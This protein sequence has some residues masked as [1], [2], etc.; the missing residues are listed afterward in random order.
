M[1]TSTLF[2]SEVWDTIKLYLFENSYVN[3]DDYDSLNDND[4]FLH[5]G[6]IKHILQNKSNI[7][8]I[9]IV[10]LNLYITAE[11]YLMVD[12][13]MVESIKND[14]L[15]VNYETN[16]FNKNSEYTYY[17]MNTLSNHKYLAPTVELYIKSFY[18]KNKFIIRRK[19][20][21]DNLYNC[22]LQ[23]E[24]NESY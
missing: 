18:N 3:V 6:V 16:I 24:T 21:D 13:A 20:L 4:V 12:N 2:P 8:S 22:L 11:N 17:I 23:T 10:N 15:W 1:E 9:C 14:L 19:I 7:L 5:Y